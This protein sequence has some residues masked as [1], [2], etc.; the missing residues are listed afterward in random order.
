[1]PDQGRIL[2]LTQ[3]PGIRGSLAAGLGLA[4]ITLAIAGNWTDPGIDLQLT[5]ARLAIIDED[6]RNP[7]VEAALHNLLN[8]A[9]AIRIVLLV[10][11]PDHARD[12]PDAILRVAKRNALRLLLAMIKEGQ[13]GRT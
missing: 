10:G 2:L 5:R 13:T 3:D 1:M 12:L 9:E 4:G 6:L 11:N 8:R 7:H